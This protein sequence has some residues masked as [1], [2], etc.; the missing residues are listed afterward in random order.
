MNPIPKGIIKLKQ[1]KSEFTPLSV[2]EFLTRFG[3]IHESLKRA[4]I[5]AQEG[6]EPFIPTC[7]VFC[8]E[9]EVFML[10]PSD[11]EE[12]I[13]I[14]HSV[15]SRSRGGL[16]ELIARESGYLV[17]ENGLVSIY[18][19]CQMTEDKVHLFYLII[20]VSDENQALNLKIDFLKQARQPSKDS[21]TRLFSQE[22]IEEKINSGD[23]HTVTLS[24]GIPPVYGEAGSLSIK[25][26]PEK[27]VTE[28]SAGKGEEEKDVTSTDHYSFSTYKEVGQDTI[29]AEVFRGSN[30]SSGLDAFGTEIIVPELKEIHFAVGKNVRQQEREDGI[31]EFIAEITG[32]LDLTE[33]SVGV[34][35]ELDVKGDVSSETGSLY[36]SGNITVGG[37]IHSLFTVKSGGNL[38]IAGTVENG[39]VIE[40]GENLNIQK[41]IIGEKTIIKVK[42]NMEADF[43]QDANLRVAG[44]LKIHGSIYSSKVFCG[45]N[46]QVAGKKVK[47]KLRGSILGSHVSCMNNMTIHSAGSQGSKTTLI[48]GLDPEL[49]NQ[50]DE[51]EK[52]VPV[53]NRK[54]LTL[55]NR[56]GIDLTKK[57]IAEELKKLSHH[58]K[59]EIKKLLEE[60]KLYASHKAEVSKRMAALKDRSINPNL[61]DLCIQVGSHLVPETTVMIGEHK[62]RIENPSGG[63]T[64]TLKNDALVFSGR[65]K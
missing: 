7:G 15:F 36:F 55:Q 58:R 26:R 21:G 61:E 13:K 6:S 18:N 48:C 31:T 3:D 64:I 30:G 39:A 41:G 60:I 43:I 62:T 9:K 29:L 54:I 37:N 17:Q 10:F 38:S 32:I 16:T 46:L 24:I 27:R 22:K 20:P 59:A 52:S 34:L 12:Y 40:C 51:M 2:E 4:K 56:I 53:I 23:I 14:D 42:G 50:L 25:V 63:V 47:G 57:G 44:D 33:T 28:K 1:D 19:P 35:E 49:K 65:K 5:I 11:L 8:Q 45:G